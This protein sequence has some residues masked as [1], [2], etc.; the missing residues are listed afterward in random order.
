[1]LHLTVASAALKNR[2]KGIE[3]PLD[4]NETRSHNSKSPKALHRVRLSPDISSGMQAVTR[5]P[6]RCRNFGLGFVAFE[7]A[8]PFLTIFWFAKLRQCF[9]NLVAAL[10]R[11]RRRTASLSRI[12]GPRAP[13]YV[14]PRQRLGNFDAGI[15]RRAESPALLDKLSRDLNLD[16]LFGRLILIVPKAQRLYC[17][18][19]FKKIT[20]AVGTKTHYQPNVRWL[21]KPPWLKP[22]P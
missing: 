20:T 18:S 19:R 9:R 21:W 8:R 17:K 10:Q 16:A 11:I 12:F 3:K 22:F 1:M 13:C 4:L 6:L 14:S 15:G 7:N 5:K 2:A